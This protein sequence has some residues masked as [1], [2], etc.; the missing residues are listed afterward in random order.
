MAVV[1]GRDVG[2]KGRGI[3]LV[4]VS[5]VFT[6]VAVALVATRLSTR[7]QTGRKLGKDDYA[8]V[9]SVVRLQLYQST[10]SIT[11]RLLCRLL[12]RLK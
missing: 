3:E 7:F 10:S 6:A 1:E 8:I 4:I 12:Y 5:I 9:A 11:T 2:I